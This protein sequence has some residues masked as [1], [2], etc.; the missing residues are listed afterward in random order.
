MVVF[1]QL[2]WVGQGFFTHQLDKVFST[3]QVVSWMC[4]F[5]QKHIHAPLPHPHP[6]THTHTPWISNGAPLTWCRA[7]T[8]IMLGSY[9]L[10]SMI[11]M[12]SRHLQLGGCRKASSWWIR[13]PN[14]KPRSCKKAG[15]TD[16]SLTSESKFLVSKYIMHFLLTWGKVLREMN[17]G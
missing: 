13:Q 16:E 4:F 6:L 11:I 14:I 1:L 9:L 2:S 10:W 3:R 8:D 15:M 12:I 17:T 5:L 7:L